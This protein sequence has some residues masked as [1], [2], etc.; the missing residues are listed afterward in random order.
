MVRS[1]VT[2]TIGRGERWKPFLGAIPIVRRRSR[3]SK[4]LRGERYVRLRHDATTARDCRIDSEW[5][6]GYR[7]R[8]CCSVRPTD[9]GLDRINLSRLYID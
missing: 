8:L 6:G 3:N 4:Q 5:S 1:D 7:S 9:W 2:S